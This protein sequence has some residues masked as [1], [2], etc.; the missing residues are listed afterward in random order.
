MLQM[1]FSTGFLCELCGFSPRPLRLK[2]F[3]A[4][5]AKF[6]IYKAKLS[7]PRTLRLF[8]AISA[9][10]SSGAAQSAHSLY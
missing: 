4:Q 3:G 9:V 2:A 7:S 8:S 6:L 1:D 5:S 10:K